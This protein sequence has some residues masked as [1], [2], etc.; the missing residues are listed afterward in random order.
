MGNRVLRVGLL[1]C[2]VVGGGLLEVLAKS[3]LFQEGEDSVEIQV[4]K[5]AVVH[6]QRKRRVPIDPSILT[7]DWKEVC[8]DSSIDVVVEAMGGLEPARTAIVTALH[9]GKHVVTANKGVLAH[10]GD[11]LR[12]V[13][14]ATH[15]HLFYEASVLGGVPVL[16]LLESY[17]RMNTF[18]TLT[19]IVNGTSN[20]ILSQMSQEGM[21]FA[22]A[23]G[24]AQEAGYAELD[25]TDDIEGIDAAN[26]LCVLSQLAFG[27]SMKVDDIYRRGIGHLDASL[28]EAASNRGYVVK[29]L[30]TLVPT[31][32]EGMVAAVEPVLVPTHHKLAAVIGADNSLLISS[33][34]VGEVSMTGPGAGALP[35]ASAVVEDLV[36]LQQP[37]SASSRW[38]RPVKPVSKVT[39]PAYHWF[40][41]QGSHAM[42]VP[43]NAKNLQFIR[44]E[45]NDESLWVY[46]SEAMTTIE[47]REAF[48]TVEGFFDAHPILELSTRDEQLKQV[49]TEY[50]Q[51]SLKDLHVSG[52]QRS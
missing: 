13:A 1:G 10:H 28:I 46:A 19:G 9:H 7:T 45:T 29:L 3:A 43:R 4:V 38:C 8:E 27:M 6:L 25:P 24:Q 18:V 33:D 31:S 14:R 39:S 20:Y 2:G 17:F 42:T 12:T 40:L 51:I 52:Q 47:I 15:Q 36:K 48:E 50:S 44:N 30:A 21:S 23:L 5:V 34:I 26:K 49:E 35:T 41:V 32:S 22:S 16:H 37:G 11:E